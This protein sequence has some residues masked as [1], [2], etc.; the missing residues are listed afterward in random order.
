MGTGT[1][2]YES[3]DALGE[4][5]VALGATAGAVVGAIG[6]ATL[7]A[8]A[9][10]PFPLLAGMLGT[11]FG[12]GLIASGWFLLVRPANGNATGSPSDD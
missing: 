4:W 9:G 7:G 10:I 1:V 6:G 2:L 8:E 5:M 12:S 3:G 11:M